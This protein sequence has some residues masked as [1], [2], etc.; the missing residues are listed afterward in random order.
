MLQSAK[1]RLAT[2]ERSIELSLTGKRVLAQVQERVR[3]T[4]ASFEEAADSIGESLSRDNLNRIVDE[5]LCDEFDGDMEAA[6][7]WKRK[8]TAELLSG[9]AYSAVRARCYF[10]TTALFAPSMR[11]PER[12]IPQPG[13][14]P[15]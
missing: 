2:L 5:L 1:R 13:Q 10:R 9:S 11:A 7:E 4:G 8:A 12:S 6:N 14:Y 3:L 15:A